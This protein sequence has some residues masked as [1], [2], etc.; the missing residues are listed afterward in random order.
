MT[1]DGYL[2][3]TFKKYATAYMRYSPAVFHVKHVLITTIWEEVNS[4]QSTKVFWSFFFLI[5]CRVKNGLSE[6][7]FGVNK[8]GKIQAIT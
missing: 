7:I 2:K 6:T 4:F 1:V 5:I 3:I 8:T